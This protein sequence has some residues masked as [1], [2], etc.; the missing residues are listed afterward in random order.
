MWSAPL[1]PVR[2]SH[3]HDGFPHLVLPRADSGFA[4]LDGAVQRLR[5]FRRYLWAV[6]HVELSVLGVKRQI[7][8]A[9][10]AGI[11][12]Q[13]NARGGPGGHPGGGCWTSSISSA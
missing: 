7:I 12:G 11:V 9:Q 8:K 3:Q 4:A 1:E 6:D 13:R 2:A 5:D 10:G